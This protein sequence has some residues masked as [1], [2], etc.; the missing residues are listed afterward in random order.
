MHKKYQESDKKCVV[1]KKAYSEILTKYKIAQ[2]K[3]KNLHD[4]VEI[5]KVVDEE[6]DLTQS[7]DFDRSKT[8]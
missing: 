2:S 8:A 3:T 1:L 5:L 4:L 6:R 7:S